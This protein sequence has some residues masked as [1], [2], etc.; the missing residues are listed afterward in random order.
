MNPG[1]STGWCFCSDAADKERCTAQPLLH[2]LEQALVIDLGIHNAA[3][4]HGDM[5]PGELPLLP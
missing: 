3:A 4:M 5:T 2:A 1:M